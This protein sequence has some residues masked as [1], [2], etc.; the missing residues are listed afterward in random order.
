MTETLES[1]T[2]VTWESVLAELADR[3]SEFHQ[4]GFVPRDFIDKLKPLGVYR[5]AAPARFGGDPLPPADFLRIIEKV[6]RVDGSAGWVVAFASALTYLAALPIET[7]AQLYR[8]GPDVVFAGGLF[9]MQPATETNRGY[10]VNGRW[11]FASGC[12]GAD[13][14][15]V[16]LLDESAS[17]KPRTAVL[18][19]SQV[20]IVNAWDVSGMRASG[21]F[22]TVVR[23]VDVDRE[24]TFVRGGPSQITDEPLFRYPVIAYQAQIHAAV[25]LGVAQAALQYA[26]DNGAYTGVTG[27]A[28]VGARA[29]YRL[30][31]AKAYAKLQSARA[32]YFDVAD[33]AWETILA[34]DGLQPEQIARI[35]LSAVNISD[36]SSKVVH[37]LGAISG[38]A[39]IQNSH[40]FNLLR[41]DAQVPQLHA[42]L[43][44]GMYD[45]AGAVLMGLDPTV[46][47]FL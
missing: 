16:G 41:L 28:P 40:P 24:W 22:D 35:R 25:G 45:A 23:D 47:G 15:G 20:E 3:R 29:Y 2:E 31:V 21:S 18:P 44:Q 5:A 6:A 26:L 32:W 4:Q 37:D 39:I 43:S 10:R 30:D 11:K 27:A 13:W 1:A 36:V 12:M 8:N 42:T 9:P 7:Q 19:A 34:G 46:P 14:I 33:E 38:A 17:G